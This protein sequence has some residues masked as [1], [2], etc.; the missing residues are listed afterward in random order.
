MLGLVTGDLGDSS[1]D[2]VREAGGSEVLGRELLE[3]MGS[4]ESYMRWSLDVLVGVEVVL[5]VLEGQSVVEDLAEG[6]PK[7]IGKRE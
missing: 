1:S 4:G 3:A 6:Q 5:Q 2:P 7:V